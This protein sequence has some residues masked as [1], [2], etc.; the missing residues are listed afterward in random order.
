MTDSFDNPC[1][2]RGFCY[3]Y[4]LASWVGEIRDR[5]R[6]GGV[7]VSRWESMVL[8][9][10]I[11]DDTLGAESSVVTSDNIKGLKSDCLESSSNQV[12]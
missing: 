1:L 10:I 2:S 8:A 3:E 4:R 9:Q 7:T 11:P 6:L 5:D 12:E